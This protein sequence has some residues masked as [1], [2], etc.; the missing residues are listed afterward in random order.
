M[1][2]WSDIKYLGTEYRAR[3]LFWGR[4]GGRQSLHAVLRPTSCSHGWGGLVSIFGEGGLGTRQSTPFPTPFTAAIFTCI[5]T[6]FSLNC[7][8]HFKCYE[9]IYIWLVNSY[10]FKLSATFQQGTHGG[11]ADLIKHSSLRRVQSTDTNLDSSKGSAAASAM[12]PSWC[13]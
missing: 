10:W 6:R 5:A 2:F 13:F 8:E 11:A 1:P 7:N 12:L 4:R 3:I 9:Y